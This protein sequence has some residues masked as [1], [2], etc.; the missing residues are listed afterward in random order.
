MV[1]SRK[2]ALFSL[3]T[4]LF[5]EFFSIMFS[6]SFFEYQAFLVLGVGK[7][8]PDYDLSFLIEFLKLQ[9]GF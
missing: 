4:K 9:M 1:L 2:P 6:N 5:L 8:F 3:V 7:I